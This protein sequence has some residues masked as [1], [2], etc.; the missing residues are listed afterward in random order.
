M[1]LLKSLLY[2]FQVSVLKRKRLLA[3][4]SRFGLEFVIAPHDMVGRTIFKR[5]DYE[6]VI[7]SY[8]LKNIAF[9]ENDVFIDVGANIGWYS[10][11]L[12][13]KTSAPARI[14]AFEPDAMNAELLESNV[15]RNSATIVSI[16]KVALSDTA[17]EKHFY[18]YSNRNLGRHSLLPINNGEVTTV[19]SMTL[20][21]FWEQNSLSTEKPRFIKIDTEGYELQ[22]VRGAEKVLADC[23]AVLAEF[24]PGF[25]KKGGVDPN[26]FVDY[27][28]EKGFVPHRITLDADVEPL[29]PSVLRNS[30]QTENILWLKPPNE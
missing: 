19:P 17:G 21:D 14:F 25:M 23:P 18:R 24:S 8:L 11:L 27:M 22:V 1:Y 6:S 28:S 5:G 3:K 29:I 26:D 4:V 9:S 12:S 20:D 10:V 15:K 16:N 13:Q 2:M 30:E 7:T